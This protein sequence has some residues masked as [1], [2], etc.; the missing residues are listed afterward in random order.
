VRL[1]RRLA[2]HIYLGVVP[3]T[4]TPSGELAIDGEGAA[5][6]WLV[7]MR[8][9]P[10]ERMLDR[11]IGEGAV[12]RDEIVTV[13]DRLAVFYRDAEPAAL[14]AEAFVQQFIHEQA[15]TRA[16]LTD[17][18]FGL[19]HMRVADMLGHIEDVLRNRAHLL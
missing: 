3:L 15:T 13:A 1:N 12:R 7:L 4:A 19:D 5:V 2:P 9:L 8:R 18:A 11:A 10:R 16:V 17:P 14:T 6:D